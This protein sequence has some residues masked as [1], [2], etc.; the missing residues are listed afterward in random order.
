MLQ[1]G[2][3]GA[4]VC[5]MIRDARRWIRIDQATVRPRGGVVGAGSA[6]TSASTCQGSTAPRASVRSYVSRFACSCELI[7]LVR[8]LHPGG[9]HPFFGIV[10]VLDVDVGNLV[11]RMIE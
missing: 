10:V 1:A 7:A 3:G 8:E 2:Q 11:N 4:D 5:G 6:E 9:I